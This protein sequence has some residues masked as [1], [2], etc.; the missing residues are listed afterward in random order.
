MKTRETETPRR[1]RSRP[2]HPNKLHPSERRTCKV[3]T[4]WTEQEKELGLLIAKRLEY[5]Q[6]QRS[7]F[8]VAVRNEFLNLATDEELAQ[9]L[10]E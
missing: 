8:A 10:G 3:L 1:R 9:V 4:A 6:D 5:G 2:A 7:N